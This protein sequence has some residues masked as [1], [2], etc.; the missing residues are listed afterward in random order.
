MALRN[1]VHRRNHKERSQPGNRR[2]FGLLEKHKDYVER[3]RDHHAKQ[4]K[5]Q[6][7]QQKAALRN[8]DEFNFGMIKSAT[9][10]LLD[11]AKGGKHHQS[12]TDSNSLDLSNDLVA[13]LKSQDVGYLRNVARSEEKKIEQ[14]KEKIRP[15]IGSLPMQWLDEKEG[16]REALVRHGL[17]QFSKKGAR[18][19]KRNLENSNIASS[20]KKTV[21]VDSVEE[22]KKMKSTKENEGISSS[23][24]GK[25]KA[26]DE[27]FGSLA[28]MGEF[29]DDDEDLSIDE[30]EDEDDSE[31]NLRPVEKTLSKLVN[32]LMSRQERLDSLKEAQQKLETVRHLMTTKGTSVRKL[33]SKEDSLRDAVAKGARVTANGLAL[34]GPDEDDDSD[35]EEIPKQKQKSLWKWGRERKK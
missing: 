13:I 10:N 32:E 29:A 8:N 5:L 9:N 25:G 28:A 16:R 31:N 4:E 18:Q 2:K 24:K 35:E 21:W 7:L 33:K 3:A 11:R 27:E 20:G 34:P 26:Y 12:R 17:L 6:R 23:S 1:V 15:S 30:D 22:A 14:I 19:S